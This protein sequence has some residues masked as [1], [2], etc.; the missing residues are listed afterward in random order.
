V[1]RPCGEKLKSEPAQTMREKI[2]RT[3]WLK[4]LKSQ[5]NSEEF[6]NGLY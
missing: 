4:A 1:K 6:M 2:K 5:V 3:A